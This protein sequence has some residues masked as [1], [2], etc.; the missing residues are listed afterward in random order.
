MR[1]RRQ[2]YWRDPQLMANSVAH[3]LWATLCRP[4]ILRTCRERRE[5]AALEGTLRGLFGRNMVGDGH[6]DRSGDGRCIDEPR[7]A[8]GG[9][10]RRLPDP[11]DVH[12]RGAPADEPLLAGRTVNALRR[13]APRAGPARRPRLPAASWWPAWDMHS[14][15]HKHGTA[16][17][18]MWLRCDD[19]GDLSAA[20]GR[21]D[22]AAPAAASCIPRGGA[23]AHAESLSELCAE[24]CMCDRVGNRTSHSAHAAMTC[25]A[26]WAICSWLR[27]P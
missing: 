20:G 13:Q 9:A 14:D 2:L 18:L 16:S 10:Q 22:A 6:R 7:R 27:K 24:P 23:R 15:L 17:E 19:P 3:L 1:L 8:E 21:R 11:A 4:I 5:H 26:K 25:P 12:E